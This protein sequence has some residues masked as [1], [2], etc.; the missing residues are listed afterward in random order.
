VH[1]DDTDGGPRAVASA[2][3]LE[4]EVAESVARQQRVAVAGT[5][6]AV[7]DASV[8]GGGRQV[9]VLAA[10]SV[11]LKLLRKFGQ[12]WMMF[13]LKIGIIYGMK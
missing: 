12:S 5:N 2:G 9:L 3:Q 8:A 10:T 7:A 13:K 11:L 4:V 1:N 6:Y